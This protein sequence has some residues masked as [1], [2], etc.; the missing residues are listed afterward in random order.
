MLADIRALLNEWK[1]RRLVRRWENGGTL[2]VESYEAELAAS[3]SWLAQRLSMQVRWRISRRQKRGELRTIW[4]K[5]IATVNVEGECC[6]PCVAKVKSNLSEA[7]KAIFNRLFH[8][9]VEHHT[10]S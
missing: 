6:M 1:Q 9:P 7:D 4:G 3:A 10:F 5:L 2:Y 8:V